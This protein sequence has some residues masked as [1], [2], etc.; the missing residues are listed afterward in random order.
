MLTKPGLGGIVASL[1]TQGIGMSALPLFIVLGTL[2]AAV[3]FAFIQD[4]V[5]VYVF[6]HLGIV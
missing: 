3:I 2:M 6:N 4:F 1:T 5:K